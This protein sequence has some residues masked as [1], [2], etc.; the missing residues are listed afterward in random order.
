MYRVLSVTNTDGAQRRRLTERAAI[1][2]GTMHGH[3]VDH[4]ERSLPTSGQQIIGRRHRHNTKKLFG[5]AKKMCEEVVK[6]LA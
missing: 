4:L 2:L 5:D 3:P 1:G 6:A